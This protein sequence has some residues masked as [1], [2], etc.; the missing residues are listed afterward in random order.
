MQLL[1]VGVSSCKLLKRTYLV[2]LP[3]PCLFSLSL[4][5]PGL[6][7]AD[8]DKPRVL[9]TGGTIVIISVIHYTF[10]FCRRWVCR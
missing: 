9:V 2:C 6:L 5:A 1:C 10:S 4:T 3:W 8:S 7:M